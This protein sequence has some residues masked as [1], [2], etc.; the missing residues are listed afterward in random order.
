[1]IKLSHNMSFSY[2]ISRGSMSSRIKTADE[3]NTKVFNKMLQLYDRK[4]SFGINAIKSGYNSVLPE[5]KNIQILP[6]MSENSKFVGRTDIEEYKPNLLSG[7]T[8]QL[9]A[10][11]KKKFNIQYLSYL[12]HEST[13]IL[14]YLLNP[15]YLANYK[16]MCE[17]D[18][19]AKNYFNL[20]EKYY[21]NTDEMKNNS[22][23]KMLALAEEETR[24]SL[25]R[26][27]HKDKLIFLNYI[28]YSMEMEFHAY[29]QDANYAKML[30]KLGKKV[31]D[32]D[33]KNFNDFMAFP[34]KIE[35]VNK[36]IKE[37]LEKN[38]TENN[39]S[40]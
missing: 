13:H 20:Y 12:M 11:K 31:D 33:L 19:Y 8:I 4:S 5:K 40:L 18:I 32:S 28:K 14:D 26:V 16:Q 9:P 21:Y 36:L 2:K 29:N 15:K 27:P 1:M 17:R 22:K 6:L 37:E 7:Y 35:I 34:E 30:Q 38:R 39:M 23:N 25:R 10:D 24:K 3:L